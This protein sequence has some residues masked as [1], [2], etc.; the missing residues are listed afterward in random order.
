LLEYVSYLF[1]PYLRR[2]TKLTAHY[3]LLSSPTFHRGVG[4]VAK[5]VNEIRHGT[6]MEE[7]GG[8]K[9]E[10]EIA[11]PPASAICITDLTGQAK[12]PAS[13]SISRM[14]SKNSSRSERTN[15]GD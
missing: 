12:D 10:R 15:D 1:L 13:S 4:K 5:K 8:T 14:K 3:Q 6:P 9:L 7:M 11:L 2:I